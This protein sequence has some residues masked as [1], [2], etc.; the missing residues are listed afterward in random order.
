MI[1]DDLATDVFAVVGS[2]VSFYRDEVLILETNG[3]HRNKQELKAS[4]TKSMRLI[5]SDVVEIPYTDL[6][7]TGDSV[8]TGRGIYRISGNPKRDGSGGLIVK[9]ESDEIEETDHS[10]YER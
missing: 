6:I 2:P 8:D 10:R 1:W 7:K 5:D 3:V 9:L 4:K